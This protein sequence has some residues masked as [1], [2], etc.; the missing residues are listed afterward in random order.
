MS[1]LLVPPSSG[2]P[3]RLHAGGEDSVEVD[4]STPM[5]RVDTVPI[6]SVNRQLQHFNLFR[7]DNTKYDNRNEQD[8]YNRQPAPDG[9]NL[10]SDASQKLFHFF[11]AHCTREPFRHS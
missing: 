10:I 11:V 7:C 4:V 8:N 1:S 2:V 5:P 9:I 6:A 3:L